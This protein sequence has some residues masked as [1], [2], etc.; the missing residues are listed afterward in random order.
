MAQ[1]LHCFLKES[2]ISQPRNIE[3]KEEFALPKYIFTQFSTPLLKWYRVYLKQLLNAIR[4]P[5]IFL[6]IRATLVEPMCEFFAF[7]TRNSLVSYIHYKLATL[8]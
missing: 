2:E 3:E 5:I 6:N 8:G 4:N 1:R 7:R